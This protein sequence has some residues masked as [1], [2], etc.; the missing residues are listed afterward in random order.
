[1]TFTLVSQPVLAKSTDHQKPVITGAK[2]TTI[3]IGQI[4]NPKSNV[5][6]K[7]NKDGNITKKIKEN[8]VNIH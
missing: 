5:K 1:M 8:L 3:Y 4:F 2:N 7:D 6:A